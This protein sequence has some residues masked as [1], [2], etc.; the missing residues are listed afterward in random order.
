MRLTPLRLYGALLIEGAAM[1]IFFLTLAAIA[2]IARVNFARA[3]TPDISHVTAGLWQETSF[4]NPANL[5]CSIGGAPDIPGGRLIMGASQRRPSPM[6]LVLRKNDW[7]I[8]DRA[9]V[10][11]RF[12][13]PNGYSLTYSGFGRGD[14]IHFLLTDQ[15]LPIWIHEFTKNPEMKVYFQGN[16]PV[17]EFDLSGTSK[18]VDAMDDCFKTLDIK[19][20]GA[21]FLRRG[22]NKEYATTQPFGGALKG[23]PSGP[24]S[25][26][27]SEAPS[28]SSSMSPATS[29]TQNLRSTPSLPPGATCSNDWRA[30]KNN[31]DLVNNYQ[32][33]VD[34]QLRCQN[35]ANDMARYGTPKW[36]GIWSGGPFTE[37]FRGDSDI[38]TG[39]AVA[40]EDHAQFQNA[41]GAYVHSEVL[42]R[43]DLKS[44]KVLNVEIVP[45]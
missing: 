11:A 33:Y 41:F 37:F 35:A 6:S 34:I 21:P 26:K 13:F 36:P 15:Q 29:L 5:G 10:K 38:K 32:K 45:R 19:G 42:C 39:I 16:E 27:N 25:S 17:W 2:I 44:N 12:V 3:G 7:K 14:A 31:A 9:A 40:V 4:K 22:A 43:Y 8:P 1:R 18:V 28:G 30:C 24:G 23:P 20:V